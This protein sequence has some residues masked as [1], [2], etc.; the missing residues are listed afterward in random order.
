MD[1]M[2]ELKQADTA[3][4]QRCR[5]GD[6]QAFRQLVE[7]LK[8]PAYFHALALTGNH[9]DALDVSQD[10]FA[11]AWS[12]IGRLDPT[13]PF[14]PWYYTILKRLALNCLRARQRRRE[15][16]IDDDWQYAEHGLDPSGDPAEARRAEEAR[17]L[18]RA[19]MR[20]LTPEDREIIALKDMHDYRY[21]EIAFM[22]SIPVGT[23]MSRL[24]TARR[25]FRA[26]ME[27]AGYEN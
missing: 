21:Q 22:L 7:Q 23:V 26:L 4:L 24:Y 1:T 6:G 12:N 17:A 19:V 25:R 2:D 20:R 13:K 3:L 9:A 14:Y 8:K 18:V 10:A 11:R 15:D 5:S 16:G 27:D